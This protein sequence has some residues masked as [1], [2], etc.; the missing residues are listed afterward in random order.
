QLR[1]AGMAD[2]FNMYG[3][4]ETCV[5]SAVQRLEPDSNGRVT[6]GGPLVNTSLYVLDAQL[7]P[8]PI[9]VQGELYIGGTGVGRGYW[10]KPALTAERFLPDPFTGRPGARMYGTGDIVRPLGGG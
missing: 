9:G 8:V 2:V 4:T 7:K 6:V 5:W 1:D 3:P 10:N